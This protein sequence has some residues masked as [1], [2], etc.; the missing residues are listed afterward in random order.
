LKLNLPNGFWNIG[1]AFATGNGSWYNV[2]SILKMIA[3]SSVQLATCDCYR[4]AAKEPRVCHLL[5][6]LWESYLQTRE[7]AFQY[8]TPLLVSPCLAFF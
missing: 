6:H 5:Y 3:G 8:S 1:F 4:N 2:W 7:E